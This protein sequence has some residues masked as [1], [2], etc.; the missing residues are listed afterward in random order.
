MKYSLIKVSDSITVHVINNY[1]CI[2]EISNKLENEIQ[3]SLTKSVIEEKLQAKIVFESYN[4]LLGV[5]TFF[6]I[7][8]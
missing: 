7:D 5:L 2:A 1:R 8:Q 3:V 6:V 4:E